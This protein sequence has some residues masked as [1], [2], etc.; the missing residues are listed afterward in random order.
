MVDQR[1][2]CQSSS[3]EFLIS[4][5]FDFNKL[6]KEGIPYMNE[7][8]EAAYK[9]NLEEQQ[10]LRANSDL[11][12]NGDRILIPKENESF[13]EDVLYVSNTCI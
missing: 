11:H 10:K 13:I 2:L 5:G 9:E 6:F 8:E 4:N 7:A 1:F 3:I 12:P